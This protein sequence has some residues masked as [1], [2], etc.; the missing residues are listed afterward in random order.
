MTQESR[1]TAQNIIK[2]NCGKCCHNEVCKYK[3]TFESAVERAVHEV[4]GDDYLTVTFLKCKFHMYT[5]GTTFRF[6]YPQEKEKEQF[7]P[8]IGKEDREG[9]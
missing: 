5:G 6:D 4:Q 8:C 1:K 3:G 9:H 7:S 2:A